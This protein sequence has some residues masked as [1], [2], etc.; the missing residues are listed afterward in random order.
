MP[1]I[2]AIETKRINFHLSE[3]A[4]A[5]LQQMARSTRRSMTELLRL[6]LGLLKIA[7]EAERN[8][9]KIVITTADGNAVKEI[10]LPS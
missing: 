1:V 2:D 10:V 9:H 6:G 3:R 7:V 4:H 5:E 8:G